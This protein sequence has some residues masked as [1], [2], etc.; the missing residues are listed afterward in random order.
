[1]K[2]NIKCTLTKK[3]QNPH[4]ESNYKAS[5]TNMNMIKIAITSL[6]PSLNLI[7]KRKKKTYYTSCKTKRSNLR[8]RLSTCI[9]DSK[10]S[11]MTKA[12][13]L[14]LMRI[15]A[16]YVTLLLLNKNSRVLPK[17]CKKLGRLLK[18]LTCKIGCRYS[19]GFRAKY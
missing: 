6:S 15:K 11:R 9:A 10:K 1:M 13:I 5:K 7:I 17:M 8:V 4:S 18:A 14:P 16:L 19:K 3:R 2:I 12:Q